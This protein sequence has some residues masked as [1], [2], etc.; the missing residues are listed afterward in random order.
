MSVGVLALP[1]VPPVASAFGGVFWPIRGS[2]W[3]QTPIFY[4]GT[5][6][7]VGV[8]PLFFQAFA[9]WQ[10]S[11]YCHAQLPAGKRALRVN[12][13][14]TA[15]CLF[16]GG[17][18]GNVF[19]S[20]TDHTVVQN[21]PRG[22]RRAY[23]T[24]V[25][26]VCD[27]MA[28]QAVLPQVI[29]GNEHTLPAHQLAALRAACPPNVH[30]IRAKSAWVNGRVSVHLMKLLAAALAP[31]MAAYQPILYFDAYKAHLEWAVFA[32]CARLGLWAVVVP[33]KMTWL[34]QPLDTHVF[35]VYK[36]CLQKAYQ[37][38]RIRAANPDISLA[39]LLTCVYASIRDVV[40]G[41]PWAHAFDANG[42]GAAQN[43]VS[44]RVILKL[45]IAAPPA[46]AAE[47]PSHQQLQA[48]FPKRMRIPVRAVWKP[49][50]PP[51]ILA[52]AKPAGHVAPCVE[53]VAPPP[54]PLRRSSARIAAGVSLPKAGM[55][56]SACLGPPRGPACPKVAS[57]SSSSAPPA[58]AI[59]LVATKAVPPPPPPP[60]PKAPPAG[61]IMTRS[62]TRS[63]AL[64]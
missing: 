44:D 22:K 49:F 42:L 25:A 55:A 46:N 56:A 1:H 41:R 61:G 29:I 52:V 19:L 24:H 14:E 51:S 38:A 40:E 50:A 36:I 4:L 45:L 59:G 8:V 3:W 16:Q 9:T 13:D 39:D 18:R 10:W 15:I 63:L 31:F 5:L 48:C 17:G 33:A 12:M 34:L 23:L 20:K 37:A 21:I 43:G 2:D 60:T 62:R 11:N 28:I 26:F 7:S 57:G 58:K 6:L 53:S 27:D 32:T 54:A 35:L 47:R 64:P 30:L